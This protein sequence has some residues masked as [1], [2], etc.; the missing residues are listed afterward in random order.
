MVEGQSD[1]EMEPMW[2]S[3]VALLAAGGL[4]AALP[5]F[6]GAGHSCSGVNIL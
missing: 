6:V 4:Y 2:P 5:H 1:R 3:L